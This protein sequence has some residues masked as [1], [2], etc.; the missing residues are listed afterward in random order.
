MKLEDAIKEVGLPFNVLDCSRDELP[1]FFKR[2]GF[3]EGVE[4]GCYK[5]AFTEKFCK[6]GLKMH[7]V[8]PWMAYQGAGR[9]QQEQDRQDFLFGHATRVLEPY[10]DCTVIR[11]TSMD[12]LADFKDGSLDFVYI[13]G[14]HEFGHVACDIVE[15]SKKVR[16]GGIVSGHDYSCLSSP[17]AR[18]V[19][20][21]VGPVVDAYVKVFGVKSFWTLGRSKPLAE[22]AKD[23]KYLS[24]FFIKE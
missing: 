10:K 4:V 9:T 8:D 19:I 13:D 12:A 5:A 22:E 11:K 1:K 2:L 20:C 21:H 6:E 17:S 18:N 14:D 15:W 24:W 16:V 7:A 23:D 3:K